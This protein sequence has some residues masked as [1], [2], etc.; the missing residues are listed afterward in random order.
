MTTSASAE[1]PLA[2]DTRAVSP[3]CSKPLQRWP[4]WTRAGRQGIGQHI[5][6]VGAVHAEGRV[7]A[8]GVRH[9][10]RRDRRAV[11]AEVARTRA[12]PRAPFLHRR[13][14]ARPAADG[15]RCSASGTRRRR[16]RRARAPAR[17]PRPGGPARSAHWR[18]TSRRSRL[19]RSTTSRPRLRHINSSLHARLNTRRS[20]VSSH[21]SKAFC[22]QA[23]SGAD[24]SGR[25]RMRDAHAQA[26]VC[27]RPIR[28]R[29]GAAAVCP[30]LIGGSARAESYPDRAVKIIVPFAAG[31]TADAIP[32]LVGGLAV[33]QMGPAGHHREPHRRCRKHRR[34]IRLPFGARRLHAACRRR[35][36]RL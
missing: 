24:N 14:Q 23:R 21:R 5:D 7:P 8:R 6:E 19:R 26:S 12:D 31:G 27:S 22:H 30:Q 10:H 16:S 11:V 1:A 17:R 33:A 15:A 13:F 34:G 25:H 20:V 2:N 35:R 29:A 32:R 36:R 3:S 9:L 18:R 4:V 28:D